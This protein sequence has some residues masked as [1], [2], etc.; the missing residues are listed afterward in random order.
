MVMG[1]NLIGFLSRDKVYDIIRTEILL[2]GKDGIQ[3]NR[4]LFTSLDLRLGMQTVVAIATIILRIH[5]SE[6]MEQHLT[7]TDTRLRIGSRLHQQLTPDIL[8]RH[9]LALHELIQFLKIL[10][11]VK[12]DA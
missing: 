12:C 11:G 3:D 4:Q 9:G 1:H 7:P 10:I 6:I 2:N 5:L 8:F